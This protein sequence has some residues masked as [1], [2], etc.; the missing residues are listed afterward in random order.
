M[1]KIRVMSEKG[2]TLLEGIVAIAITSAGMLLLLSF[3][4]LLLESQ[5]RSAIVFEEAMEINS[6]SDGI[7]KELDG[8]RI[9]DQ[10]KIVRF[11]EMEY[12][13]YKLVGI[14]IADAENYWIIEVEDQ[15]KTEN[16]FF[17]NYYGS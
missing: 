14:G 7:R 8:Q 11:L 9:A 17:I 5:F 3:L 15:R 1:N 10:D 13:D 12:P 16:H 4:G 2:F 6:L